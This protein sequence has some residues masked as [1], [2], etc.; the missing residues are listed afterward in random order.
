MPSGW[1]IQ[2]S[3][4]RYDVRHRGI[5]DIVW[6]QPGEVFVTISGSSSSTSGQELFVNAAGDSFGVY[7]SANYGV[8]WS[9]VHAGGVAGIGNY[10]DR[11]HVAKDGSWWVSSRSV[12]AGGGITRG[13]G[14]WY[15]SN[16]GRTWK[17]MGANLPWPSV[18]AVTSD[19]VN[20]SWIIITAL[21][22]GV[23][24]ADWPGIGF[25]PRGKAR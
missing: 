8:T 21:G 5:H 9:K 4:S 15:S 1:T 18:A 11:F 23:F 16:A 12:G 13:N 14:I 7:R 2:T 6:N 17:D 22:P 25:V 3:G 24:R 10:D 19:P 20:A